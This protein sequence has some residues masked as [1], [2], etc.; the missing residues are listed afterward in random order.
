MGG[1]THL[2]SLCVPLWEAD[3][4]TDIIM[5]KQF[6]K[7]IH[8][9]GFGDNA[10]DAWRYHDEGIPGVPKSQRTLNPDFVLNQDKYQ[11][12]KILLAGPNFGCGSSREHAVWGLV[13][14]G[15]QAIIAPSFGE[16]FENNASKNGLATL[17]QPEALVKA[18]C[19]QA[20]ATDFTISVDLSE[21][22]LTADGQT[23]SFAMN[24]IYLDRVV[25]GKDDIA[26]VLEARQAVQ[27]Y[28]ANRQEREPWVFS[29][30][31]V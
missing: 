2:T 12:S 18:W 22:T 7:S 20:I 1:W 14:W 29:P 6:L 4:D 24:A 19:D 15:F 8:R 25:T 27:D 23:H 3:V 10:F 21:Q 11:E 17:H 31:E 16:I 9:T 13:E 30:I 28:E 5:P 26:R